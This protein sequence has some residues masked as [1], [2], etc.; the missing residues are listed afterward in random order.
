MIIFPTKKGQLSA[1]KFS[2]ERMQDFIKNVDGFLN[3]Q[4]SSW[5]GCRTVNEKAENWQENSLTKSR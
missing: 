5:S 4:K 2:E 3:L 1:L